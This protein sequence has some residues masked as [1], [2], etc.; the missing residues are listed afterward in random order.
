M[1]SIIWLGSGAVTKVAG[2]NQDVALFGL[3]RFAL[4]YQLRGGLKAVALTDIVQVTLLVMGGLIVAFL[5]L[6]EIGGGEGVVAGFSRLVE[7]APDH[8]HMIL[9]K[10]DPHYMDLPGLSVLRSEEHTSELQSL[11]RISYAV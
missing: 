1:P 3:G 9:E 5:T 8:F 7:R 11:M 10:D 4:L 6:G 2:V